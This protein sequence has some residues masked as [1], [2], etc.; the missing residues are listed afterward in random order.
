MKDQ[1]VAYL[2]EEWLNAALRAAAQGSSRSDGQSD[3]PPAVRRA[4]REL[5]ARALHELEAQALREL[6]AE[7][8][9]AKW[10]HGRFSDTLSQ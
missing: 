10:P 5:E 7:A 1:L 8:A 2:N 4:A 3:R 6:E 9:G